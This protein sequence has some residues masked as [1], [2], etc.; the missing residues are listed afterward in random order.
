M[1]TKEVCKACWLGNPFGYKASLGG[2]LWSE[3]DEEMWQEGDV[4]CHLDSLLTTNSAPPK[5]CPRMFEHAV[6][7]GRIKD[8][9]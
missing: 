6:A 4:E 2:T 9:Q 3:R 5:G 1:L 8:A 7:S